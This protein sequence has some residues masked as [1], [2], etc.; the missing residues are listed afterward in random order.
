[1]W[2]FYMGKQDS[3]CGEFLK[4]RKGVQKVVSGRKNL[5]IKG[6]E[7]QSSKCM[8]HMTGREVSPVKEPGEILVLP[9]GSR[10]ESFECF[11]LTPFLVLQTVPDG[12]KSP[13][14]PLAGLF[15]KS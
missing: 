3:D 14:G 1:M 2:G 9:G 6:N 8:H 10:K 7:I 4:C 15:S 11:L 12:R 13:L 5:S